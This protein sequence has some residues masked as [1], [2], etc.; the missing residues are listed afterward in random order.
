MT[1]LHGIRRYLRAPAALS[2]V[3]AAQ[4]VAAPMFTPTLIAAATESPHAPL[5]PQSNTA[6]IAGVVW[7]DMSRNGLQGGTEKGIPGAPVVLQDTNG[8]TLATTTTGATGHYTFSS[9]A[10]GSYRVAFFLPENFIFTEQDACGALCG[11]V[12]SDANVDTGLTDPIVLADGETVTTIAAGLIQVRFF[13][14]VAAVNRGPAVE[15]CDPSSPYWMAVKSGNSSYTF[16]SKQ[17]LEFVTGLPP[18]VNLN[19]GE[20]RDLSLKWNIFGISGIR[21]KIEP[22]S[23]Y[24]GAAGSQGQR[25]V[26][27]NG[28][29]GPNNYIYALNANE[30]GYG[31]F[32]IE[33]FITNNSGQVVGYNEK[34]LCIH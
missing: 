1:T 29:D 2:V 6:M 24:C 8:A 13:S 25:D 12:D 10:A 19:Y 9:L 3:L 33:L 26:P 28:S 11:P 30:F 16:C 7:L 18:V 31:G 22:N 14:F 23:Q 17:D 34:F 32:K 20:N 4:F 27:V 21:L 15:V 5:S